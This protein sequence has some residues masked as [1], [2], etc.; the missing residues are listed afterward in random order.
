MVYIPRKTVNIIHRNYNRAGWSYGK[1]RWWFGSDAE[2]AANNYD[3]SVALNA[4]SHAMFFNM[5][6]TRE[7]IG[8]KLW[9]TSGANF[10][11]WGL[12][13]GTYMV[14][15]DIHVTLTATSYPH[16]MRSACPREFST[17]THSYGD[18]SGLQYTNTGA[19]SGNEK[20]QNMS[21]S[22]F[23]DFVYHNRIYRRRFKLVSDGNHT[24]KPANL[25]S[26]GSLSN[27]YNNWWD[28]LLEDIRITKLD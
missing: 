3:A 17:A 25:Y 24:G 15:Q 6:G 4:S 12:Y 1:S 13:A 10:Y 26:T 27:T 9:D 28:V 5:T 22:D 21:I 16:L 8:E 20:Y 23:H 14:E 2:I 11:E 19:P 7:V 18:S